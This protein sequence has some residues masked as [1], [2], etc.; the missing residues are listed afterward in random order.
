MSDV[1]LSEFNWGLRQHM[2]EHCLEQGM[3]PKLATYAGIGY[4]MVMHDK[5]SIPLNMRKYFEN[6][7]DE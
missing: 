7:D 5:A 6:G 4:F 1:G 2:I 3:D